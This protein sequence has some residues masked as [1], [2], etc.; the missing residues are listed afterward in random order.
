M[1][2]PQG[3]HHVSN[4]MSGV[5]PIFCAPSTTTTNSALFAY[6]V[7]ELRRVLV[8]RGALARFALVSLL[9]AFGHG[10]VA[11]LG[12]ALALVLAS[13]AG[14]QIATS[15]RLWAGFPRVGDP[16]SQASLFAALAFGVI[17]IKAGGGV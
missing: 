6:Y 5:A 1:A 16:A 17:L 2:T 7:K 8:R 13:G 14:G 15:G 4:E 12:S 11:L 9:H 3:N 10:L